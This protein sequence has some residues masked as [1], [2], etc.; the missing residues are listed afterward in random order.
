MSQA[1]KYV[2]GL[3]FS[4]E[5]DFV[6]LLKKDHPAWQAGKWNGPGGH[7]EKGET[8]QQAV[9]RE[10]DEECGVFVEPERWEEFL[11]LEGD[12]Y[13]ATFLRAFAS[14]V[15]AVQTVTSE[16][17]ELFNVRE[18]T[19]LPTIPNLKWI[20]PLALDRDLAVPIRILD[21]NIAGKKE[22]VP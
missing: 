10:V 8:A 17:V 15:F 12:E 14:E 13:S 16:E 20:I 1:S 2:V 6:A 19:G 21:R 4:P 11:I 9:A 5:R 3:L 22:V 7:V 18:A